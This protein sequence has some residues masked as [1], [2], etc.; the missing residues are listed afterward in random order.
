MKRALTF[1]L[2][3]AAVVASAGASAQTAML[4]PPDNHYFTSQGSWGQKYPDQWALQ[5]IGFDASPNSAWRL[6]KQNAQPVVV[7]VIDTGLDWNHRNIDPENIWRNP[8]ETAG[9]GVDDDKNGY[10]DDVIGWDFFDR[11]GK[12]WDFDGHGTFVSGLIAG[13]W[14]DKS[15]I[16][17]IN[18]FARLMILKA[19]NNFGHS[20][21]SYVAEAIAYAADNG[22]RVIN[23]SLGGKEPTKVAQ[24]AIDYAYSKGVV[25]VVAAGNEGADISKFGITGSDKVLTRRP[26]STTSARCFPISARFRL[27][28][29]VSIS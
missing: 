9:N 27:P 19:V 8:K 2:L 26:V 3:V 17:G 4:S 22:A 12:P 24:A 7:A 6:V 28:R 10:V 1:P 20:R 23:L 16:A 18:P 11:D 14:K 15:G 25:I 13:S 5:R 29:P 21:A